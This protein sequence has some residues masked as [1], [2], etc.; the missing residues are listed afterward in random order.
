MFESFLAM[1]THP[2][3]I[4]IYGMLMHYLKK[5][6]ESARIYRKTGQ[7]LSLIRYWKDYPYRSAFSVISALAGFAALYGTEELTKLTAFGLGYMSESVTSVM[8]KR[9]RHNRRQRGPLDV[10]QDDNIDE[11]EDEMEDEQQGRKNPYD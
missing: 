8:G 2:F 5:V 6:I 3:F 4:M 10:Y 1:M 7:K 9:A 11:M